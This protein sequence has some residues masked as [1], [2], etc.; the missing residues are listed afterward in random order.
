MKR[1]VLA[2]LGGVLLLSGVFMTAARAQETAAPNPEIEKLKAQM[3]AQQEQIDQLR[4]AL[5]EEKKVLNQIG[6]PKEEPK[7]AVEEAGQPKPRSLGEVAST[8]PILPA[9]DAAPVVRPA[10]AAALTPTLQ[11][12]GEEP[13][14]PLQLRIGTATITPI[15]FIDFT[16]VFRS[17]DGGSGI[18]TSFGSTPYNNVS[19]G[20]GKLTEE[21]FSAQNSRIGA[22]VD[23]LVHGTKVLAYWESD[24][25]GTQSTNAGVTS[26]SNS[27]RMRLYFVDLRKGQWEIL[28]G[29]SW[30]MMTPGR[31]GISPLPADIFYSQDMDTNY[32]VGIPWTRAPQFRAVYHPSDIV[33]VGFALETAE[34]YGGGSSGGGA[35]VLPSTLVTPFTNTQIDLG[36]A[37]FTPPNLTPDVQ[38]K[39][40]FDPKVDG[41]R[42]HIEFGGLL[43][44]F[45]T[46]NPTT[47]TS[48]TK[49]GG[50]GEANF[51]LEL[52][53]G[54]HM[55]VNTFYSDGGGRYLFG[56]APDLAIAASGAP[57]P[58]HA[59]ATVDGFEYYIKNTTLFAY[60]GGDY[61]G[62][63]VLL[64]T[65]NKDAFIGYGYPKSANSQN[66]T[67]QEATFG[68]NQTFWKNPTYG[69]LSFIFQYSY[70]LRDP[71]YVAAGSPDKT[72]NNMVFLD[73]RYTL[74]GQAPHY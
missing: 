33:T 31:V 22:R 6:Q 19:T 25:L 3:A 1:R 53:K 43:S 56:Q 30:S 67:I 58:M 49:S 39:I 47:S 12:P 57:I 61:I 11:A 41:K 44:E 15:G 7:K 70:L 27:F 26:N 50:A 68:F 46:Y 38:A 10:V 59:D 72:H 73:L 28:G 21:R 51:N 4:K 42:M 64:D 52:L 45:K 5:E 66:R 29:Q 8:T 32:Q 69:A 36:A 62:K 23:A 74:P 34:Q 55:L 63:T 24:F 48:F 71:W 9:G 16:S 60:Y 37:T 35:I 17:A 14:S 18:G 54:F 65:T 20:L 2:M 13:A 40:A